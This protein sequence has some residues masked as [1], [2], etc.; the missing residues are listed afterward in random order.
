ME[1]LE[2]LV[3]GLVQG[4]TE[5]LPVSSDGHLSLTEKLFA[6]VKGFSRP[7]EENLFFF[8][9]LHLGTLTAIAIY[10]RA[11]VITGARGLLGSTDVPPEYRRQPLIRVGILAFV[12]TTP[13]VP[14]VFVKKHIEATFVGF[15]PTA[16]GFLITA[17]ILIVTRLLD[18]GQPA[19]ASS[20]GGDGA[21][22]GASPTAR[23]QAP[24]E[25][26]DTTLVDAL[27]I[28]IA[29]MFAP[30]PGVSRSGLTV[31]AALALG[32]SRRWAVGFSLLIAF[33]AIGGA[34]I[35]ELRH[36][37][38]SMLTSDRIQQTIAA[39]LVAGIVGYGAI[40][41]LVKIV[42]AGYLWYFSVYLIV[43]GLAVLT[44]AV[45]GV[46]PDAPGAASMDRAARISAPRPADRVGPGRSEHALAGPLAAGARP[47]PGLARPALAGNTRPEDLV[48]GRSLAGRP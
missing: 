35:M 17:T 7:S 11:A 28:G 34:T 25:A 9:M 38:P 12:A 23:R 48:L 41:W 40:I 20:R 30:L 39:T 27:L 32:L 13:L 46:L 29:Q 6:I 10:Y 3:L 14:L 42:R 21:I 8:V 4:L 43:L 15:K 37:T 18:R 36:V 45:T 33:P 16:V 31:A 5:F 19:S 24:K 44:A 2:S 26:A 1:W 47:D 22:D